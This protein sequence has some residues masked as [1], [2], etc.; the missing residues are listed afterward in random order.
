M[1]QYHL[2]LQHFKTNITKNTLITSQKPKAQKLKLCQ[3]LKH[4]GYVTNQAERLIEVST[5][6]ECKIRF[7]PT[8]PKE[9]ENFSK[10]S[11]LN[12]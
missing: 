11:Q 5:F 7:Y 6:T 12:L 1:P 8:P 10:F 9:D 3:N 4:H 2:F